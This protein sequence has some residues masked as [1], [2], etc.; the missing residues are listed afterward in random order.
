[1][2]TLRDCF[3]HSVALSAERLAHILEH[4]EMLG[5]EV[6]IKTTL[7]TP[8]LVRR[9]RSE[10]SASLFTAFTNAQSLVANGSALWLS[11]LEM[12]RLW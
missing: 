11:I 3:G 1:M 2:V 9:S 7:Q 10:P 8:Q 5:L 12:R 6:E 4:P